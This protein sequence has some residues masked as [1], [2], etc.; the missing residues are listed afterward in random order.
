[1]PQSPIY[2][3][4]SDFIS[5]K[6]QMSHFYQPVMLMELVRNG[7]EASVQ[8]IAK[9]ILG[10]DISQI[11][12]YEKR[13]K[14]MVG[15]VL[16][17]N[18]GITEKIKSGRSITGYK[19]AGAENLSSDETKSLIDMCQEQIDN[20]LDRRGDK[21]WSHRRKSSGYISGTIRYEVLKRAKFRCELCGI[22]ADEKALEVDH[23]I[24]RNQGGQ[25][26]ISNF[27]A[28]CYSC[29]AMKRDRDDTDFRGMAES[30]NVREKGCLFCEIEESRI[31]AEIELCFAVR[32]GHSV[33]E[34]HTLIIPKRHTPDFFNLHQPEINAVY[35]L[36]EEVKIEIEQLDDTVKGFNVGVNSGEVA[37]QT[38][39]HCHIHLIP[40]RKG[41]VENPRGGV[42]GV[43]P[44]K[45]NY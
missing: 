42:R 32:D 5:N 23:I 43:I 20:F 36:L 10:H 6:M 15:K 30:Y 9:A 13:T 18:N 44:E 11:E 27:Q 33:T 40:R 34:H 1:M 7:G 16:T 29:N 31:V 28:L 39:N 24:P 12:Y 22:S 8:E 38:I 35:S 4:L 45:Q 19:L 2:N 37:G 25:D 26:E 14:E 3:R 17:D 21:I 41:D